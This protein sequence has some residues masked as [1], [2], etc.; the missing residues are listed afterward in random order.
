MIIPHDKALHIIYGAIIFVVAHIFMSPLMAFAAVVFVGLAKEAHDAWV[1]WQATGDIQ[2]G[3]HGVEF[4]DW[5]ATICGG[6]L[7]ALPLF[8]PYIS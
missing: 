1:N 6:V 5:I 8:K 7:A 3:P 4:M 2:R